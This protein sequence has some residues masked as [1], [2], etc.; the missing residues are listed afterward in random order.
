MISIGANVGDPV[1]SVLLALDRL[2]ALS[3]MPLRRSSLW[4]TA[5]VDCAPGTPPFVN[6]AAA[7]VPFPGETPESLLGKPL[8]IEAEMGR[9]RSCRNESRVIDLDLIAFGKERRNSEELVLPHPRAHL[10][11]FVLQPL[12]EIVPDFLLPGFDATVAE[13]LARLPGKDIVLPLTR[14]RSG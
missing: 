2:A 14:A 12:S 6:A 13:L 1:R 8:G 11:R 4:R 5:P 7:I 10:R 9:V 3:C